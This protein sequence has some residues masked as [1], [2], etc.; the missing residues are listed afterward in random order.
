[1]DIEQGED[2]VITET[3]Q[4]RCNACGETKQLVD[5]NLLAG[6]TYGRAARCKACRV[7]E[8]KGLPVKKEPFTPK[9]YDY[10]TALPRTHHSV[11]KWDGKLD[12]QYVRNDGLKHI[13]SR[14]V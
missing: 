12:A 6:G 5:F 13:K 11:E 8:R 7:L 3:Y 1:M 14:G 4:K 2:S 10:R 9:V